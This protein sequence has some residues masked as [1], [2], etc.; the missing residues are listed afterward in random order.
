MSRVPFVV[1]V[2]AA[3][4]VAAAGARAVRAPDAQP[5]TLS[6]QEAEAV[7]EMRAAKPHHR[8]SDAF[9]VRVAPENE[10][11]FDRSRC[12]T[13]QSLVSHVAN[14]VRDKAL[15]RYDAVVEA[16][17]ACWRGTG[18]SELVGV[19]CGDFT[20]MEA[21]LMRMLLL[22]A[23]ADDANVEAVDAALAAQDAQP[24]CQRARL[25][26]SDDT[27]RV[28]TLGAVARVR[29]VTN[30]ADI[31][32]SSP[33]FQDFVR[34]FIGA[35]AEALGVSRSRL[36]LHVHKGDELH[37]EITV[38][39]PRST[40][41]PVRN[42]HSEMVARN[43][44]L[45]PVGLARNLRDMVA[46]RATQLYGA[47]KATGLID[48]TFPVDVYELKP[49]RKADGSDSGSPAKQDAVQ[50]QLAA[51]QEDIAAQK[52]RLQDEEAAKL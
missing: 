30:L 47:N 26:G 22:R 6:E 8:V 31:P 37:P 43:R 29:L 23:G 11:I 33:R 35:L 4:L 1:A 34:A 49:E 51:E 38:R 46:A 16:Q 28:G 50:Q 5:R 19:S 32:V 3:A 24:F 2:L 36:E 7:A 44:G 12:E 45:D 52:R 40:D 48:S 20:A 17:A 14:A 41:K 9:A 15:S 13:C 10:L 18:V 25:C 21:L 42:P 39:P 27:D